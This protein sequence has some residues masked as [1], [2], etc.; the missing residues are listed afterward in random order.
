[1]MTVNLPKSHHLQILLCQVLFFCALCCMEAY[2]ENLIDVLRDANQSPKVKL[3]QEQFSTKKAQFNQIKSALYPNI[4]AQALA[5]SANENSASSQIEQWSIT[6]DMSFNAPAWYTYLSAKNQ[7]I[8]ARH[9]QQADKQQFIAQ[10]ALTYL[11]VLSA[12]RSQQASHLIVIAALANLKQARVLYQSHQITQADYQQAQATYQQH[13]VHDLACK[14]TLF[15]QQERLYALTGQYYGQLRDADNHWVM[16]VAEKTPS[17]WVKSL[18]ENN[19]KLLALQANQ[20]AQREHLQAQKT[21]AWPSI[22]LS[23]ISGHNKLNGILPSINNGAFRRITLS[24]AIMIYQGGF[25]RASQDAQA[26]QYAHAIAQSIDQNKQT[27]SYVKSLGQALIWHRKQWI[28]SSAWARSAQIAYKSAVIKYKN[29]QMTHSDFITKLNDH[30]KASIDVIIEQYSY[31]QDCVRL[32]LAL[33][34]MDTSFMKQLSQT[35]DHRTIELPQDLL[36]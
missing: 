26:A 5:Q 2:A 18:A 1:M 12:Y 13:V 28:A 7:L 4:K 19:P 29:R 35:L 36:M 15:N 16:L 11:D 20:Q 3:Y 9:Q 33:G 31:L 24:A 17:A 10:V 22:T 27:E 8:A 34:V 25:I 14:H 23:G 30:A 32:M 6:A 21:L